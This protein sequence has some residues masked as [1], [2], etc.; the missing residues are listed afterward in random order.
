MRN[1]YA[2]KWCK[3]HK[4]ILFSLISNGKRIKTLYL[5]FKHSGC[6]TRDFVKIG[7]KPRFLVQ[8]SIFSLKYQFS[9][10][11]HILDIFKLWSYTSNLHMKIHPNMQ[12]KSRKDIGSMELWTPQNA[13]KKCRICSRKVDIREHTDAETLHT[14]YMAYK[15]HLFLVFS[16]IEEVDSE[17]DIWFRHLEK[18]F[19]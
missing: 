1:A 10:Y 19:K 17:S 13:W 9:T 15:K 6:L 5:A 11:R 7:P 12:R 16:K 2:D 18:N 4:H 3:H 14:Q 8:K